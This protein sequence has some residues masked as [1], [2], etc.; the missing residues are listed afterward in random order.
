MIYVLKNEPTPGAF[1]DIL[2]FAVT[3]C[4]EALLVIQPLSRMSPKGESVL[5]MF[6][7]FMVEKTVSSKWPGSKL[8]GP[9]A[10][11]HRYRFDQE[12]SDL[13][14]K[15]NDRLYSWLQPNFPEN[16]CLLK[17]KKTPWFISLTHEKDSYFSLEE[18][19][20]NELVQKIPEVGRILKRDDGTRKAN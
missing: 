9:N 7:P 5:K 6:E 11:V 17:E 16:F 15:L 14:Q 20:K 2:D 8:S 12:F 1:C 18:A 19:E 10:L 3:K 13:M 4:V